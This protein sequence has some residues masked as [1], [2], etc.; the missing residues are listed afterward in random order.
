VR[1]EEFVGRADEEIAVEGFDVDEAVRGVVDGV[2][3]VNHGAAAWAR[4]VISATGLMVPTEL[5][6]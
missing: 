6:A 3:D 1:A 5:D 2:V 4:R